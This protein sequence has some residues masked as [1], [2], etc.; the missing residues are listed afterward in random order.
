MKHSL[1]FIFTLTTAHT[2]SFQ[3]IDFAKQSEK[4]CKA[5][6]I[7]RFKKILEDDKSAS[8]QNSCNKL[9]RNSL[10]LAV[11]HNNRIIAFLLMQFNILRSYIPDQLD[12]TPIAYARQRNNKT[13]GKM[14]IIQN[15]ARN[16]LNKKLPQP[17]TECILKFGILD[18]KLLQSFVDDISNQEIIELI[19][20]KNRRVICDI[21]NM[22]GSKLP[23]YCQ[24]DMTNTI[25]LFS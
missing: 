8:S 19:N 23:L 5:F 21:C 2:N 25:T 11:I 18:D 3:M 9:G 16:L 10:H 6:D 17:L 14:L 15:T 12:L 13:I 20:L 4:N 1:L 7:I 22:R 24:C